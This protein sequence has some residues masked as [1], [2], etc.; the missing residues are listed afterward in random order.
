MR[1]LGILLNDNIEVIHSKLVFFN[2]LVSLCSLMDIS[3]VTG[4]F[5][6][7]LFEREDRLLKLLDSAVRQSQMV[8]DVSLICHEWVVLQRTFHC[9]DT[10]LV[11]FVGEIS[12]TKFVKHLSIFVIDIKSSVK[13]LN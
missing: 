6:N 8:E 3:Q 5:L 11:F 7:A 13:I 9:L 4:D 12:Q 2:H 10:L 1:I